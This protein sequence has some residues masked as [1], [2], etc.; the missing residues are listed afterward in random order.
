MP[1]RKRLTRGRSFWTS[2]G[3]RQTGRK[4]A[5]GAYTT[6]VRFVRKISRRLR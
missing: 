1:R 3:G 2:T 6:A 4:K 5:R